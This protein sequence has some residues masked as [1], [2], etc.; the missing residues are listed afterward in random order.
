M[1]CS[2]CFDKI[3]PNKDPTVL[4]AKIVPCNHE[5]HLK[6]IREWQLQLMKDM[7]TITKSLRCPVCRGQYVKMI[8]EYN[9]SY[10]TSAST[11]SLKQIEIDVLNGFHV[12]NITE[13]YKTGE[14]M[15]QTLKD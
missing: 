4:L 10:D 1:E 12:N 11:T 9:T 2:I 15:V 8:L 7:E 13:W 6:C 3:E 5:F 14:Q